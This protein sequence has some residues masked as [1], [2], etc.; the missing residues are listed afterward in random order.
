MNEEVRLLPGEKPEAKTMLQE[1]LEGK[2]IARLHWFTEPMPHGGAAFGL[3]L[4]D[5]SRLVIMA[6]RPNGPSR[7]LARVLF[8]FIPP[9]RIITPRL[10]R[11]FTGGRERELGAP[12]PDDVQRRV[13]GQMIRAVHT[14]AAPNDS[15]GEQC[16]IELR[17]GTR[18]KIHA[19]PDARPS[20]TAD[21]WY[22]LVEPPKP[23]YL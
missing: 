4:D 21:L 5:Y 2:I 6:A 18:L 7:Y 23:T 22:E 11:H 15:G 19:L 8:R 14:I 13:E 17:D 10:R 9:Q 16:E 1:R 20:F 3:E 12:L